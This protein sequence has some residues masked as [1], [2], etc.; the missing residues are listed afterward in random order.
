MPLPR[1]QPDPPETKR[2]R[3]GTTLIGAVILSG[4]MA[5]L[6]STVQGPDRL[7]AVLLVGIGTFIVVVFV[8]FAL[9][10]PKKQN[11]PNPES[12]AVANHATGASRA[13]CPES[14]MRRWKVWNPL[15]AFLGSS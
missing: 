14:E 3:V 8:A 2:S 1:Y 13:Q 4:F 5:L 6:G 9:R 15:T 12:C 7:G 10:S 11:A